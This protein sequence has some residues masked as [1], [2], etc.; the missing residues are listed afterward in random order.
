MCGV[1]NNVLRRSE[2]YG[3]FK[4]LSKRN[5]PIVIFL[6]ENNPNRRRGD[7]VLGID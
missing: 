2:N 5:S 3:I 4:V 1:S 7:P 6:S